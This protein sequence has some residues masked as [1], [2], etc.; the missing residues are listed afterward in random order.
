MGDPLGGWWTAP[1]W[2]M[3]NHRIL[4]SLHFAVVLTE[5]FVRNEVC[6]SG[7]TINM[8]RK[9]QAKTTQCCLPW[10]CS[11]CSQRSPPL[12]DCF[13]SSTVLQFCVPGQ[14]LVWNLCLSIQD[15][16]QNFNSTGQWVAFNDLQCYHLSLW[17]IDIDFPYLGMWRQESHCLL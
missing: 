4:V 14:D 2:C 8:F 10:T 3:K 15:S 17:G 13:V 7:N 5:I 9:K 16:N 1:S 11:L 12:A 6:F